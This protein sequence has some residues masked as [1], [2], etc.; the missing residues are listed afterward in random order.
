MK[1]VVVMGIAGGTGSGKT[2]LALGVKNALGDKAVLLSHD[3][4]YL[5]NQHMSYEE[6]CMQN[7]DHP[8]SLETDLLIRHIEELKKG[9]AIQRPVYS[10]I[11]HTRL[12]E[13]VEVLPTRVVLIEGVLLLENS[14]LRELMDIKVFVDTD[15][16]VRLIRRILRDVKERGRS[17]DSVLEQY[18]NTVKPMHDTFCEPSK[19]HADFIIPEGGYN[20]V[21][22]HMIIERLK[23]FL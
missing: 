8:T 10:F 4:Y 6:R 23:T 5:K 1:N 15:P 9:N 16:D 11:T 17:L 13:T 12:D 21:V 22:L 19:K 20:Q 2:T 14:C 3:F 7:Y 18:T